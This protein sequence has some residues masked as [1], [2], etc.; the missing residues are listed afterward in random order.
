MSTLS[1]V[2]VLLM[3]PAGTG[4]TFVLNQFVKLAKHDGKHVRVTATTLTLTLRSSE[5]LDVE[6]AGRLHRVHD[7]VEI[8]LERVC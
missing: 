8:A 3:G 2:N 7:E 6:V 5:P 4:K 1:G